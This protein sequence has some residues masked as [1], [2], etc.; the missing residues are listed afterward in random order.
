MKSLTKAPGLLSRHGLTSLTTRASTFQQRL[1]SSAPLAPEAT[2]Q[3]AAKKPQRQVIFSGIQPTGVPHLGNY[4]GA[5][6]QWKR[7]QD[8]A[9]PETT[10]L[11]FSVVDLHAITVP[12]QRGNL[13]KWKREMLAT[14]LAI[15]LDPKRCTIFYQSMVPGHSE[16][17]WI[18]SCTAST[19]YLS[20]MTQWKSKL[21]LADDANMLDDKAKLS[22]KHGLF[23]YPIL[24]AA[25]ILVH[26]ATHV[27][28]GEDQRQHLE[29]A[30]ECVTNFNHAYK[31]K[32]LVAPETI[33]SPTKRVMSLQMP[34]KKMSK[35]DPDPTSRILLTDTPSEIHSKILKARTDS[36]TPSLGITFDPV[37]RPGVSNLLQLLSHFDSQNR[38]AQE[39]AAQINAEVGNQLGGEGE[40]NPLRKLKE[41]VSEVVQRELNPIRERYLE[42]LQGDEGKEGGYL[43][44]VIKEGARKANESAERTMSRVR[45]AVELGA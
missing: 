34:T 12:Q 13:R 36:L 37:Q 31:G 38:S 18:L 25:D 20:R 42:L 19:G 15:G 23:S 27:P 10:D 9:D 45:R 40:E 11:I 22:L 32:V 24:Q 33:L 21:Q 39:I 6:Q 17:Q 43:D 3:T 14:L 1:Y 44:E 4:L 8:N 35:S 29:F 5:L 28:V 30:R 7:M 2:T 16:L 41:R 26:R